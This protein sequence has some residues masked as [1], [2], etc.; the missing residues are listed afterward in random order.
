MTA[1]GS[2]IRGLA[3]E[4]VARATADEIEAIARERIERARMDLL[5]DHAYFAASLLAIPMRGTSERS[6][7]QAVVTDGLCIAYRHDLVSALDRPRVR[8]LLMHALLHVLLQHPERGRGR[9]WAVWT[10]ACDVAV[11]VLL[12]QL[13]IDRDCDPAYLKQFDGMGAEE[14]YTRL[15]AAPTP[16][17]TPLESPGDGLLPPAASD[18]DELQGEGGAHESFARAMD[19]IERPTSVQLDALRRDLGESLAERESSQRGSGPGDGRAEIE[20]AAREEVPWQALLARFMCEPVDREWSFARPNRKHLWRGLYLPGPMEVEGG[21]FAVA[22]DTSGSMSDRDLARVL[23]EIDAIRRMCACEL[24]VLQFDAEI[25]AKAEFTRW[26]D[27]DERVGSTKVMRVFGRGGTDLC[28]PFRWAEAERAK[29][30][31]ISALIVCT[32]GFGPLP[33]EAPV[34]TPVLFLLTPKHAPPPFGERIVLPERVG[35][36]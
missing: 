35:A 12:Y 4:D 19:G 21:H 5:L 20:A 29:G 31:R 11:E 10:A 23:G 8:V 1:I 17:S 30:R 15:R 24:T 36:A 14:I 26:N 32:D 7:T 34:G 3:S 28:V 13:G 6:I 9:D 2:R 27:E 22:I 16:R 18:S 25:H 33:T